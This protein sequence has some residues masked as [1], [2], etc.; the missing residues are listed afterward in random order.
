[1]ER[2]VNILYRLTRPLVGIPSDMAQVLPAVFDR[3]DLLV[4]F[5]VWAAEA[6][7]G[8]VFTALL[9]LFVTVYVWPLLPCGARRRLRAVYG[10]FSPSAACA[11]DESSYEAEPQDREKLLQEE[12]EHLHARVEA[13]ERLV[14]SMDRQRRRQI[15]RLERELAEAR[16]PWWRR[17]FGR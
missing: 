14:E 4:G 5:A 2:Y 6:V 3:A 16:R 7:A 15:D 10:Y 17:F 13:H 1:M 12:I 9:L 8:E 11:E